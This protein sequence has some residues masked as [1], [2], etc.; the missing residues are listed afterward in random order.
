MAAVLL[1]GKT[2]AQRITAECA[3]AIAQVQ[4]RYGVRPALCAIQVGERPESE[5]YVAQQRKLCQAATIDYTLRQLPADSSEK[6]LQALI[7]ELNARPDVNGIIVQM[8]LPAHLDN[9]RVTAFIDPAKDVEGVHS[10]NLGK[11]I[12]NRQSLAPC[13]A[14]AVIELLTST[15]MDLYGKEAVVVG[16]SEIVGKPVSL[17]LLNRYV[18]T[19]VCHIATSR[20]GLLADHIRRAEILVVAVGKPQVIAGDWI[21]EGAVVIDVGI[22]CVAGKLVGDVEFIPA[23]ERAAFITPVPG[24]VGPLTV[25][26]LLRNVVIATQ[27]QLEPNA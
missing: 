21:R 19:S 10:E 1:E 15:G 18:T 16:H 22:N 7:G 17:M 26:M 9:K 20:R 2:P 11:L 27:A 12:L 25:A 6:M 8:P 14:C 4:Q 24:G 3:A 23:Q 5:R 13:T